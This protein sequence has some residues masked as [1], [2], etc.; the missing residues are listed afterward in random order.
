MNLHR[1]IDARTEHRA[2]PAGARRDVMSESR[3][4]TAKSVMAA[5]CL[6]VLA[7]CVMG[8]D[9]RMQ[10]RTIDVDHSVGQ[11]VQSAVDPHWSALPEL[12][13]LRAALLYERRTATPIN[14]EQ[15]AYYFPAVTSANNEFERRDAIAATRPLLEAVDADLNFEGPFVVRSELVLPQ[16]YDFSL[17][18]FVTN[19]DAS[20]AITRYAPYGSGAPSQILAFT[21][22]DR[23]RVLPLDEDTARR[24]RSTAMSS[25]VL[26]ELEV[27]VTRAHAAP[28]G[29]ILTLQIHRARVWVQSYPG[30]RIG[31]P[32]VEL[33][34]DSPS[35]ATAGL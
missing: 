12:T 32:L 30:T 1:M 2:G 14:W 3:G 25:Q 27:T 5:L 11:A 23:L 8:P 24:L 22:S 13:P 10:L 19:F 29:R 4:A 33:L 34:F 26:L 18:Q 20:T 7:S 17:H 9:G 21:N 28:Q 15:D 6:P 31:P 35:S 16:P